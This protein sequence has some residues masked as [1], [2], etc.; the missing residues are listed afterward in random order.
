MGGGLFWENLVH[1]PVYIFIELPQRGSEFIFFE[2]PPTT[3]AEFHLRTEAMVSHSLN[4]DLPHF[5]EGVQK[6]PR[7]FNFLC[8]GVPPPK[9]AQGAG[10]G[11]GGLVHKNRAFL[12]I[13]GLLFFPELIFP[14]LHRGCTG[15]G[16]DFLSGH[17]FPSCPERKSPPT[18]YI[19]GESIAYP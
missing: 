7:V 18:F 8:V 19:G 12:P 2:P 4:E 16:Y 3:E 6:L 10:G 15:S 9:P 13:L 5:R 14:S 17:A 11:G 1:L